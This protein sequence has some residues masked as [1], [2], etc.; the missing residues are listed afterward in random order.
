MSYIIHEPKLPLVLRIEFIRS[1][2]SIFFPLA[3]PRS[4]LHGA[5]KRC[6]QEGGPERGGAERGVPITPEAD[7]KCGAVGWTGTIGPDRRLTAA[8][9][10][11]LATGVAPGLDRRRSTHGGSCRRT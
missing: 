2:L 11:R 4:V 9:V 3:Y 8:F 5:T 1:K 6:P 10:G 7:K